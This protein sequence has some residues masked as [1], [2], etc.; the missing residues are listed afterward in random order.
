MLLASGWIDSYDSHIDSYFRSKGQFVT[1][2]AFPI[3]YQQVYLECQHSS[4]G[5]Q[6][7]LTLTAEQ[8][9]ARGEA[10]SVSHADYF[11]GDTFTASRPGVITMT[12][13]N[14]DV[15]SFFG[16]HDAR[17]IIRQSQIHCAQAYMEVGGQDDNPDLGQY[18]RVWVRQGTAQVAASN[19]PSC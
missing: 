2:N 17:F 15:L 11:G 10:L 7:V 3:H 14:W 13:S 8:S 4:G 6:R 9:T 1:P 19:L 12:Y 18:G 16:R 5:V